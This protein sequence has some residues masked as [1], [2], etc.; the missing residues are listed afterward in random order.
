MKFKNLIVLLAL[1]FS[2]GACSGTLPV[3][4]NSQS[5]IKIKNK[6]LALGEFSYI[7]FDEGKVKSNQISNTAIGSIFIGEDVALYF[8]RAT[9][10]ELGNAG[11]VINNEDDLELSGNVIQFE[12]DDLGYSV[13]W[14]FKVH[15]LLQN[16]SKEETL[17]DK[18][19]SAKERKT[20]KFGLPSDFS[21]VVNLL[22]VDV[23]EQ[24]M[25]DIN[26]L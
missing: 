20:G 16:K 11:V 5:Y 6:E 10:I 15:Y 9:A 1:S 25:R 19:Y 17:I 3:E 2:V 4:Y 23:I 14:T 18:R 24:L 13:D 21:S 8:K 7:A 22:M 12:A 26:N